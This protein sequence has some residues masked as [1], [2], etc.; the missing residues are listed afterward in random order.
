MP[1][2]QLLFTLPCAAVKRQS[3]ILRVLTWSRVSTSGAPCSPD[4]DSTSSETGLSP[5]EDSTA[6]EESR[7]WSDSEASWEAADGEVI[8]DERGLDE[9]C[10]YILSLAL[11]V[12]IVD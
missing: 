12:R 3:F 5:S 1:A 9:D 10:S 4:P 8:Q 11:I 7:I 6:D 2:L